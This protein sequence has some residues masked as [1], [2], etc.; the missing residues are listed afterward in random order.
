MLK[1]RIYLDYVNSISSDGPAYSM[2]S[3]G[4]HRAAVLFCG[5]GVNAAPAL[6][7]ADVGVA[8]DAGAALAMET[9]DVTLL[10]PNLEKLELILH[11]GRRVIRKIWENVVFSISVKIL[12]LGFALAGKNHLWVAIAS[13]V[14]AMILVTLNATTLLTRAQKIENK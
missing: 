8:M 11:V 1:I 2:F 14:G 12:V 7:I 9:A 5:D 3:F 4:K 6:T 10:D 13:D